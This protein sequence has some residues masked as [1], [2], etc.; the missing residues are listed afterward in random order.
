[1]EPTDWQGMKPATGHR[2]TSVAEE[3]WMVLEEYLSQTGASQKLH[4]SRVN[5][6]KGK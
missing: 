5:E 4:E 6:M 1:M 2:A 3:E